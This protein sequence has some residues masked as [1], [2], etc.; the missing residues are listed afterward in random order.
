MKLIHTFALFALSALPTM[1]ATITFGSTGGTTG[2]TGGTSPTV[3]VNNAAGLTGLTVNVI[4]GVLSPDACASICWV[5]SFTNGYGVDNSQGSGSASDGSDELDGNGFT[6]SLTIT[7]S[8]N[9]TLT[10]ATFNAFGFGDAGTIRNMTTSTNISSFTSSTVTGLNSTGTS[11]RFSPG[12]GDSFLLRSITFNDSGA[13]AV[14][15]PS[16]FGLA[17]ISLLGVALAAR[18]RAS[19]K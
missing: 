15:E 1:A 10:G 6:D 13:P 19:R 9:V 12:D 18:K 4:A 8:R 3:T 16:T 17:G 7:F 14:P 2:F 5:T 11:F